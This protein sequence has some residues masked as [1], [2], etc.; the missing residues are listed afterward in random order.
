VCSPA[1][2]PTLHGAIRLPV[3]LSGWVVLQR[4]VR[5]RSPRPEA[6]A[7]A[8]HRPSP[9]APRRAPG[10]LLRCES[11]YRGSVI[12]RCG[13]LWWSLPRSLGHPLVA[14]GSGCRR[15]IKVAPFHHLQVWRLPL[16][17]NL[18]V[19]HLSSCAPVVLRW[20]I[21]G[22]R[23]DMYS[24]CRRSS[25]PLVRSMAVVVCALGRFSGCWRKP[26]L[27]H[28]LMTVTLS[29]STYLLEGVICAPHSSSSVVLTACQRPTRGSAAPFSYGAGSVCPFSFVV[30][31]SRSILSYTCPRFVVVGL[32]GG[33]AGCLFM[34]CRQHVDPCFHLSSSSLVGEWVSSS[35]WCLRLST[36]HVSFFYFS[37]HLLSSSS[38]AGCAGR[39]EWVC[40]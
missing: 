7:R 15:G 21:C 9:G 10:M 5:R 18:V 38:V 2:V 17:S 40:G 27:I 4:R 26:M 34:T 33:V 11:G 13:A 22:G 6:G 36:H 19:W 8:W 16:H 23:G 39:W 24:L 14:G 31:F 29:G 3:G 32:G 37:T 1:V 30:L 35:P 20:G 28:R 25:S 12:L